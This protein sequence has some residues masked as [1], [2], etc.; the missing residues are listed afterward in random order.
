MMPFCVN[1]G[2]K[3]EGN[4]KFCPKCG[5]DQRTQVS[6]GDAERKVIAEIPAVDGGLELTE[7]SKKS[8]VSV[9]YKKLVVLV[10]ILAAGISLFAGIKLLAR[11][12]AVEELR[13]SGDQ[14]ISTETPT[15]Q[16]A[17]GLPETYTIVGLFPM[18]GVLS[19]YGENNAQAAMLASA[20]INLWLEEEGRPWRLNLKVE[21]T[22]SDRYG[23]QRKMQSSLNEDIKI[24]AG[25]VESSCVKECLVFA[26]ANKILFVSPASTAL[27]LA[28]A[29]DWLYRFIGSD[30]TQGAAVVRVAS[31]IGIE[32]LIIGWR[33]D[34]WGDGL[35]TAAS[36]IARELG[37]SVYTEGFRYDPIKNETGNVVRSLDNLVG[38][39]VGEGI[40]S[41]RI[42]FFLIALEE[43]VSFLEEAS[44][45][46]RLKQIAW[47]GSDGMGLS[48]DLISSP[49]A[50]E[51]A[52]EVKYIKP[53][54]RFADL[55]A[56]TMHE[57]VANHIRTAS[58]RE[59]D[60][61]SFNTYDII[62]S[63]ALAIDEVGYDAGAVKTALPEVT[64]QWTKIHGA[65]GHVVLNEFGDRAYADFDLWLLNEESAWENIGFYK[66]MSD[67][68][69]W[70][71]MLF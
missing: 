59:P 5:F 29:D 27:D 67:K 25:P 30:L 51:L 58:G 1:C 10:I 9:R 3:L 54:S 60:F 57:R 20:D 65:S 12:A 56:S 68:I 62:W 70:L 2:I 8:S 33:G 69:T 44:S 50:S 4:E 38:D 37:I 18:T 43:E 26:N 71:K 7:E 31:D 61:S 66:G 21:D 13:S 39:L 32:H 63:L 40:E 41:E 23:G 45:Y 46:S 24:F 52:A 11:P 15:E 19:A 42:G 35:C 48:G 47:I 34:A 49:A 36:E 17:A 6:N 64:D 14:L 53:L 28:V 22:E 16:T 55:P